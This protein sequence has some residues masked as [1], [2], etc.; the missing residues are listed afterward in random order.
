MQ[1]QDSEIELQ[2]TDLFEEIFLKY[3]YDF[4]DYSQASMKRRIAQAIHSMDYKGI[5]EL[6]A[7]ALDDPLCFTQLL[8]FLTIP[9]SEMFR[10]P[11]YYSAFREKVIPILRTYPSI[12][13]WIAGCSTGEEVY[14]FAIILKEEGLL[15]RSIIYATDINEASLARARAGIYRLKDFQKFTSNYQRSGGKAQFSDYY[16]ADD[17]AAIFNSSLRKQ[18]T[19][20][21]HSLATDSVFSE[22]HFISCRNV[23]IYFQKQLQDRAIGLFHES[24]CRKGFLGLGSKESIA[25]SSFK[26]GFDDLVTREKLYRKN[27][28][29]NPQGEIC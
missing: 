9:V 2:I 4:R 5:P 23:L 3:K 15:E 26:T 16:T 25:F 29:S 14:S 17:D 21:D 27:E 19:F 13:I 28:N 20:T 6:K 22:V 18:I 12:K 1:L 11:T 7:K 10:D 8:Q 24:L